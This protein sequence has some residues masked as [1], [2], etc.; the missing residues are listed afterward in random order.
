MFA[1]RR[2]IRPFHRLL[3]EMVRS[4]EEAA[5][6]P[7]ETPE[8]DAAARAGGGDL[9][10]RIALRARRLPDSP[11]LR[12]GI[13][14]GLGILALVGLA[15]TLLLGLAGALA[16]GAALGNAEP[17]SLPLALAL[18]VGPNLLTL[19]LWLLLLPLARRSGLALLLRGLGA[20]I[21]GDNATAPTAASLRL[22]LFGASG[23]WVTGSL[24]HAAWLGYA[25]A[26]TV[27]LLVLL[28]V[29]S[30]ALSWETTLLSGEAL[31]QW[32]QALSLAPALLGVPGADS[33]PLRAPM[34]TAAH[35]AWAAWL[36]VA[37]IAYGVVPRALALAACLALARHT[38]RR[39]SEDLAQPGYA[40][41]R[42]RLMPVHGAARI[43]DAA[44]QADTTAVAPEP[45]AAVPEGPLHAL[46][47]ETDC[48]ADDLPAEWIWLGGVDDG[49]SREQAQARLR[50]DTVRGL[51]V[52][53]RAAATPDRGNRHAIESLLQA[54]DA[55]GL[56]L[57]AGPASAQRAR[58]WQTL[59]AGLGMAVREATGIGYT[60][61]EKG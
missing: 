9:Q 29:R 15:A 18:V 6:S 36:L 11:A 21:A 45:A 33:L 59:A 22:L 34:P 3:M 28:S 14:R 61:A 30:Y 26:A 1:R 8:A 44:P 35:E 37:V 12:E 50:A 27:V 19:L 31:R 56:L 20:R 49:D 4:R 43:V 57:L 41:L 60:A 24:A 39:S 51:A 5:G 40:R 32:A 54:A 17:V 42:A 13:R 48:T 55:P 46:A 53:V 25:L 2:R 10:A 52:V 58:D 38:L 47:L 7:A 16:A 23:R